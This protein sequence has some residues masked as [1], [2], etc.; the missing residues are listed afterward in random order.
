MIRTR[1]NKKQKIEHVAIAYHRNGVA[2]AG[3]HQVGFSW[4]DHEATTWWLLAMVFPAANHVVVLNLDD[5]DQQWRGDNFEV[6]LREVIARWDKDATV[7][8]F[9]GSERSTA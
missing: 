7:A 9:I 5:A 8:E 1:R 4:T 6:A 2:G 3:Y